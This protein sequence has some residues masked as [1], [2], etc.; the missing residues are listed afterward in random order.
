MTPFATGHHVAYTVLAESDAEEMVQLLSEAFT[1]RDPPAVAVGVT[2]EEFQ[3][4]VRLLCPTAVAEGLTIVARS[5]DTGEMMGALLAGDSASPPAPGME[6]L[7]A[8]FDPILDI[9]S[10]LET[11]YRGSQAVSAGE[12]MHL[13]LLGVA[14]RFS[15]QGVAHQLV[16][17]CTANGARGGYRVAVTEATNQTSQ[18]IFRKEGFVERARE[19]YRDYRF[20]GQAVFATIAGHSGAIL[21]DKLLER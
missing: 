6:S 10:K 13:F 21:M 18:H 7:S 17:R 2:S 11:A 12:S 9:L 5:L 14:E 8:R 4:F 3:D 19:S 1:K 20:D 16:A 15:G